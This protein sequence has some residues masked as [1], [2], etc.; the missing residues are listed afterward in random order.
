VN[1]LT[2]LQASATKMSVSDFLHNPEVNRATL[3][4]FGLYFANG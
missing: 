4:L 3:K 2:Q 1:I